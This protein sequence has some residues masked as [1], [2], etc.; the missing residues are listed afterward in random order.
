MELNE[1]LNL[2][3]RNT[4]KPNRYLQYTIDVPVIFDDYEKVQ[5]LLENY[6]RIVGCYKINNKSITL[7]YYKLNEKS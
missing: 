5:K 4:N 6:Y 2:F 1:L 7:L 3:S